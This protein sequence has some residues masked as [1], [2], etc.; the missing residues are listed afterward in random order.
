M[1]KK[2]VITSLIFVI[3]IAGGIAYNLIKKRGSGGDAPV[4]AP[5]NRQSA[6]QINGYVVHVKP[7]TDEFTALGSLIPDEEVRLSFETSGRITDIF[8]EEGS[9]VKKG[10]LLAKVNDRTLQA[11]LSRFEAQ[12]RLVEARASRQS[13]LFERDAISQEAYEQANTEL[14]ILN[15]D[16]T[17]VRA[18]IALTELR[19]PF[20]GIIGLR[21]VSEGAFA[22]PSTLVA[23]LTKISPIKIEFTVNEADIA[24]IKSGTD[25]TFQVGSELRVYNAKV[26]AIES[27]VNYEL[28]TLKVRALY[29]NLNHELSPGRYVSISVKRVEIPD[30]IVIPSQAVIKEMGIDKVFLYRDG[31][32]QPVDINI[33]IRTDSEVQVLHGLNVGDTLITSGTL[34]LRSGM[35]VVLGNI[36]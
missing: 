2:W 23:T 9:M 1:K 29:P 24:N 7:L 10:D 31:K 30:A 34:Q 17:L 4:T 13:T 14:A 18:N 12:Q 35:D 19:A 5:A 27:F 22:T 26:Y 28:R 16:M 11:Q 20:D 3:F 8:F 25:I 15:A 33:G 36:E 21:Q 32:A 6:L